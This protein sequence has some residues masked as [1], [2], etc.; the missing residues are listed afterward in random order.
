MIC[1]GGSLLLRGLREETA[2][3]DLCVSEML[4]QRL[5]LEKYPKDADRISFIPMQKSGHCLQHETD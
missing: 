3:F 1:S 4:A 5:D 2:D